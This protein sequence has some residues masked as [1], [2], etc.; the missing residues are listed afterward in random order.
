LPTVEID[1]N[2]VLFVDRNNGG[3]R[4]AHKEPR[5]SGDAFS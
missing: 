1:V 4:L 3:N 2:I 5:P